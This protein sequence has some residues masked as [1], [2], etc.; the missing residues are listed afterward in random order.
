MDVSLVYLKFEKDFIW[1]KSYVMILW[2]EEFFV[3]LL[4][5]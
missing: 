4:G 5:Y 2:G 1:L 3:W